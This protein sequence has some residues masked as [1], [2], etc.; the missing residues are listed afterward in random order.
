MKL[1]IQ[2]LQHLM[3]S[4]P[5][6]FKERFEKASVGIIEQID[7]LAS[8][9]TEFSNFAK[10]PGIKLEVLNLT[11]LISS[12]V[13]VFSKHKHVSI[14]N[15]ILSDQ[16]MVKVDREQCLRVFNNLLQNAVQATEETQEAH[17]EINCEQKSNR[18][19]ISIKDNGCG[20]SDELKP[21]I[22]S[23]NFTTKST[24]SGLGLAMVKNIME[25]FGGRIYFESEKNKGSV[26]YI[27]FIDSVFPD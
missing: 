15:Q 27:E 13:E 22:F 2:Y 23:P 17:I 12:T 9:A 21:K 7:T 4:N 26:F 1:N 20:I 24:G 19:I 16:L 3:K 25:G 11:E 10:L 18:L 8:I 5:E 6:D 14:V